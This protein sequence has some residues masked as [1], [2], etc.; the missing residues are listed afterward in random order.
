MLYQVTALLLSL[1]ALSRRQSKLH[2]IF[3]HS[4]CCKVGKAVSMQHLDDQYLPS[5]EPWLVVWC[6]CDFQPKIF[7]TQGHITAV[8]AF[9]VAYMIVSLHFPLF[10]PL[11][12]WDSPAFY[13]TWVWCHPESGKIIFSVHSVLLATQ[14]INFVFQRIDCHC[15]YRPQFKTLTKFWKGYNSKR[16]IYNSVSAW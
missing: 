6:K 11:N 13:Y 1:A 10:W 4:K 5:I 7:Q 14:M 2:T 15:W 16:Y 12:F 3:L 8:F 9:F